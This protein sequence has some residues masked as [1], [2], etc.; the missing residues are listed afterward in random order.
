M[1]YPKIN[2]LLVNT[3]KP[4]VME[5]RGWLDKNRKSNSGLINLSQAAPMAL[6]PKSLIKYL[7]KELLNTESHL[8]G[9]VLG[10]IELRS[11]ISLTWSNEYKG[12][13][14][15]EN[16]A[17]TSGCNHAFCA[18]ISSV[19]SSGDK[20]ILPVPWYF[21]HEMW[22][23]MQ[24]IEVIPLPSDE[25][26]FPS[27]EKAES[28]IDEK[29]KAIVLV[30][31][32]NPTGVEYPQILLN[33]FNNLAKKNNINL[34]LDET[35]K[36]FRK[37]TGPPHNLFKKKWGNHL[38]HLYSFSK[39][40]RITGHRVGMLIASKTLIKEVEK[41]LDTTS[42]CPNRLAQKAALFGLTNLERFVRT[43]KNKVDKIKLI[44]TEGIKKIPGWTLLGIGG[45]FA[46]LTYKP[47]INSINMSKRLLSEQSILTIPGSMFYPQK[48]NIFIKEKQSIR[49]AFANSTEKEIKTVLER[50]SKFSA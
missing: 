29:V 37:K 13:I 30:T 32:N 33:K 2:S 21:N 28:L 12:K 27:A 1:N 22:L 6:P 35:Y 23:N 16:V 38:I 34:I 36:N 26:L 50:L 7:S 48:K 15:M 18:A 5:V 49:I 14:N 41:F 40:Y 4:P 11:K 47:N 19:A 46:Y 24:G 25:N 8:Y 3:Q 42:I 39:V 17:I 10:D 44:F 31:P 43:E 20:V 9:P 45:Y